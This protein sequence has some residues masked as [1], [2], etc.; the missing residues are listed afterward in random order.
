MISRTIKVDYWT[1]SWGWRE[2]IVL[3]VSF[4]ILGFTVEA[5]KKI[6][7]QNCWTGSFLVQ[8]NICIIDQTMVLSEVI[9]LDYLENGLAI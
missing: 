3:V 2:I 7:V 5:G 4:S 8:H 1:N 6:M 9:T